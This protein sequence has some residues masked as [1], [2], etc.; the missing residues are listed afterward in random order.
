MNL[1]ANYCEIPNNPVRRNMKRIKLPKGSKQIG[2]NEFQA[3]LAAAETIGQLIKVLRKGS[4]GKFSDIH[5]DTW[6]KLEK[7]QKCKEPL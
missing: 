3:A 7:A 6:A 5:P 1:L 4:Y 2:V